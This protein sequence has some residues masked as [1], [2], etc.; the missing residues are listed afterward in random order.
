MILHFIIF[1]IQYSTMN[2]TI[3]STTI[4]PENKSDNTIGL[5]I[6]NSYFSNTFR[7]IMFYKLYDLLL[8]NETMV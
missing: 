6:I 2:T 5:I 3:N 1:G 7:W 8:S 4:E